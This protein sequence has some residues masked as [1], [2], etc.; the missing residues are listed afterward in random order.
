MTE[1]YEAMAV[2]EDA[3]MTAGVLAQADKIALLAVPLLAA[4]M[5][6]PARQSVTD[7]EIED[8]VRLARRLRSESIAQALP[9]LPRG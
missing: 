3:A 6:R 1:G 2:Q 8:V 7:G 4:L 9:S 5:G